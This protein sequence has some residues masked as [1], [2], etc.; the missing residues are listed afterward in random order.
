MEEDPTRLWF[1]TR[2]V[3]PVTFNIPMFEG[4]LIAQI[5]GGYVRVEDLVTEAKDKEPAT[6][7]KYPHLA[8]YIPPEGLKTWP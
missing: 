3:G 5:S 2:N 7:D 4:E 6:I 8:A 1:T